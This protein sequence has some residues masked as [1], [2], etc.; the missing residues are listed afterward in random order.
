MKYNG[1]DLLCLHAAASIASL[2]PLRVGN[3]GLVVEGM[4]VHG[5]L[6]ERL[7]SLCQVVNS[8]DFALEA[9][10]VTVEDSDWQMVASRAGV[11]QP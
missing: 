10:L 7:R 5:V 11:N 9:C 1:V 3:E 6:H 2:A 8:T 4:L